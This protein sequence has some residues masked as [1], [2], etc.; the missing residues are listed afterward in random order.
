MSNNKI[1]YE[2]TQENHDLIAQGIRD[3]DA[4]LGFAV[5][6]TPEER[7][8]YATMGDKTFTFV[9]KTIQYMDERQEFR[10]PY[11]DIT[12]LKRD[13]NLA[14]QLKGLLLLIEPV[15]EKISDTYLAAGIDAY[16]AARKIYNYIKTASTS[17]APGSDVIAA[18]LAKRF[19]KRPSTT[20]EEKAGPQ[21]EK[22]GGEENETKE[23]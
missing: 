7:K 14:Q 10:P 20:P 1:S 13:M 15:V 3:V 22:T 5:N 18:E 19:V 23:S 4:A 12:E 21:K 8:N 17:G 2:L 6:L 11:V 9:D 16:E